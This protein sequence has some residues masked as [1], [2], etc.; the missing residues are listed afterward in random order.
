MCVSSPTEAEVH[1]PQDVRDVLRIDGEVVQPLV[2]HLQSLHTG[3]PHHLRHPIKTQCFNSK[4]IHFLKFNDQIVEVYLN[5]VLNVMFQILTV[6]SA[7]TDILGSLMM[8]LS[9]Y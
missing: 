4:S 2:P 7:L 3:G 8:K 5:L 1:V 6:F 9:V